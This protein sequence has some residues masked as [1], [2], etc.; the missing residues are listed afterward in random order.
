MNNMEGKGVGWAVKNLLKGRKIS[1]GEWPPSTFVYHVRDAMGV[2]RLYLSDTLALYE[3]VARP[4][5]L[6]ATDYY[7]VEPD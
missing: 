1:R 4:E 7:I 5:D 2:D 3:W 6:L